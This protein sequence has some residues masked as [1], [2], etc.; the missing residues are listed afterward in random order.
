MWII[1]KLAGYWDYKADWIKENSG[2][3]AI[4]CPEFSNG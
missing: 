3:Y 4:F 2:N 1:S